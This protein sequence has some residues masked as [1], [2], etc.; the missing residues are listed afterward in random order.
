MC[1][2]AR[3]SRACPLGG[4]RSRRPAFDVDPLLKKRAAGF[5]IRTVRALATVLLAP[6]IAFGIVSIDLGIVSEPGHTNS[7][8]WSDRNFTTRSDMQTWLNARGGS[9]EEWAARHP[10]LA[11]VIET[12]QASAA[13]TTHR[14]YLLRGALAIF[15]ALLLLLAMIAPRT[16][17]RRPA[18]ARTQVSAHERLRPTFAAFGATSAFAMQARSASAPYLRSFVNAGRQSLMDIHDALS[19]RQTKRTVRIVLLYAAYAMFAIALG[20]AVAIH[21]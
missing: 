12:P 20:T 10:S 7:V 13:E 5:N 3:S 9:Y 2:Q 4:S 11:S 17:Y 15:A 18:W 16:G 14:R 21:F 1:R 19:T 8:R 6:L